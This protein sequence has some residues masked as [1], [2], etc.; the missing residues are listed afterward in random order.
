MGF[1]RRGFTRRVAGYLRDQATDQNSLRAAGLRYESRLPPSW[2]CGA[3]WE[4]LPIDNSEV[5][6]Q[7]VTIDTPELRSAAALLGVP[8]LR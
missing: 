6:I 5:Q 1:S 8:L 3:L 4:P 2:E 7:S